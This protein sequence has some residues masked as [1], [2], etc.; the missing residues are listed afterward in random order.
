MRNYL[1]NGG[2][3]AHV[4]AVV[5]CGAANHGVIIS[6]TAL[7]GSE[8]NGASAFMKDLNSTPGEVL[9]GIRFLTIRSDSNDKYA[10]PDGRYLGLPNVPTGIGF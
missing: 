8:F 6:D 10:Q 5:L 3:A 9:P 2:G 4:A 7:V 1:K